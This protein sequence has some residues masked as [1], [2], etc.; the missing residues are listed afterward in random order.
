MSSIYLD[1]G[2][3]SYPKAPGVAKAIY[4]SLTNEMGNANRSSHRASIDSSRLLFEVRELAADYF[5][6]PQSSRII[7]TSGATESLNTAIY[8]LITEGAKVL[9]TPMEHN[10]VSRPLRSLE[11]RKGILIEY[12]TCDDLGSISLDK[13]EEELDSVEPEIFIFTGES[14]VTGAINPLDM[15]I[16]IMEK[17]NI[18][19]IIDGTQLTGDVPIDLSAMNHGSF[20]CSAHKGLL[21]PTGVG[22]MIIGESL[23]PRPLI[24]GGTGSKSDSDIQPEIMPDYYESGT[25]NFHGIAGLK[26]ALAYLIEREDSYQVKNEITQYLYDSLSVLPGVLL[27]SPSDHRGSVI[28]FCYENS[29]ISE[30]TEY[31]DDHGYSVRMGL[32]CSPWAHTHIGT[33]DTGGTLRVSPGLFTTSKDID[34]F[35][36]QLQDYTHE[37]S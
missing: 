25:L 27:Y 13:L 15:I 8:G 21:G 32:H 20:C 3:T 9:T 17:K 33:F 37:T 24:Y 16:P 26:T 10:S 23:Q 34:S 29:S 18:P 7:F 31:L 1:N 30:L 2:A 36:K 35:I 28:S 11:D 5:S 12:V 22:L 4:N 6:Y 14:N 19:Y